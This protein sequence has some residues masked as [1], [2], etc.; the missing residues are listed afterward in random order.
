MGIGAVEWDLARTAWRGTVAQSTVWLMVENDLD[1]GMGEGG[2]SLAAPA[3]PSRIP[4]VRV[5]F[6]D[7]QWDQ[8]VQLAARGV[9]PETI[10]AVALLPVKQVER[11]IRCK[12]GQQRIRAWRGRAILAELEHEEQLR[13]ML[14]TARGAIRDGMKLAPAK[15]AAQVG[16]KLHEALIQKPPQR[17][18]HRVDGRI[19]HDLAPIFERLTQGIAQIREA[20]QGKNPLERVV[21]GDVGLVQHR[22]ALQS[23]EPDAGSQ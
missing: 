3:P 16:L 15:D 10:A 8:V 14:P 13:D 12:D 17:I 6:T 22:P 21:R 19:E 18:E 23:G 7:R 5:R 11:A 4:R 2:G 1:T 9:D 20:Q